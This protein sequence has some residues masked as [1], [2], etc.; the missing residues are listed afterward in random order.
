MSMWINL[1]RVSPA[2]FEQLVANPALLG[3]LLIEGDAEVM[4]KLGVAD[5]DVSGL[6]YG[7]AEEMI[8]AMADAADQADADPTEDD[9][10]D[11]DDE[12][13]DENDDEDDDE[14]DDE[15][16]AQ[17]DELD[18]DEEEDD[19][20]LADLGIDG[21]LPYDAGF[22]SA[23][24]ISPEAAKQAAATSAALKLDEEVMAIVRAAAERG[25][26]VVGVVS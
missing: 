3:P 14:D 1:A 10:D 4:G 11:A 19:I 17:A 24:Y 6:D 5:T 23:F 26:Y 25:H 8:E 16:H 21:L 20:V 18:D 15:H 2:V 9:L 22:G 7:A 12:D 13:D